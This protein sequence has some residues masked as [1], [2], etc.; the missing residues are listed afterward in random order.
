MTVTLEMWQ[1]EFIVALLTIIAVTNALIVVEL[2]RAG[3]QRER[4]HELTKNTNGPIR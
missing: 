2:V 4:H 1:F 3:S